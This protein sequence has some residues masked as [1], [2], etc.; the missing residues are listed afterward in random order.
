MVKNSLSRASGVPV[1]KGLLL[2]NSASGV[3]AK[4]MNLAILVW[5]QQYL[6]SRIP[7]EE[8][9]LYPLFTSVLMFM[10]IVKAV[11]TS[12]IARYLIAARTQDDAS[13]I[14]EITSSTF[15]LNVLIAIL[16]LGLAVPAA[17]NVEELLTIDAAYVADARRMMGIMVV[18]FALRLAL[19]SYESGLI[20]EQ[21]FVLINV[22]A[23]SVS[24]FRVA[25]LVIFVVGVS[26]RVLWVVLATELSNIVSLV[27]FSILS[28]RAIPSLRFRISGV[29]T[30]TLKKVLTFGSWAFV[31]QVANR[32]RTAADPIILNQFAGPVAV[33]VYYIGSL[34]P[35]NLFGITQHATQAVLP[36]MTALYETGQLQRLRS[37]YI[38]Y[39]RVLS[40]AFFAVGTPIIALR[41]EI[42]VL[43]AGPEYA[44]AAVVLVLLMAAEALEQAYSAMPRV[45]FAMAK[46][47]KLSVLSVIAQIANLSLTIVLVAVFEFGAIGAAASTLAIRLSLE[48]SIF[49]VYGSRLVGLRY[50]TWFAEALLR[51]A[52]PAAIAFP[53]MLLVRAYWPPTGWILV[54]VQSMIGLVVFCIVLYF[55]SAT[56]QDR[57]DLSTLL[58]WL[59][60]RGRDTAPPV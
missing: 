14:E 38:R 31:A 45:A 47:R 8:Y 56:R 40:W 22:V 43:Y 42:V 11:F 24:V 39:G 21:K 54:L 50:R 27:V 44:T 1:D 57:D 55:L 59:S 60:R 41:K 23:L 6:L 51:G 35:K 15:A 3:I 46:M 19:A 29:R 33:A 17:A 52:L 30:A 12:G 4:V 2:R 28:R 34:I 18:S 20:V 25:L 32:I 13:A 5:L 7:A 58:S 10:L 37:T 26:P 48:F 49:S 53:L 36:S 16:F 9:S